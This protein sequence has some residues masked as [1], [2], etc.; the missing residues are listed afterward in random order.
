MPLLPQPLLLPRLLPPG[1]RRQQRRRLPGLPQRQVHALRGRRVEPAAVLALPCRLLWP[2]AVPGRLPRPVSRH[3]PRP[4]VRAGRHRQALQRHRRFLRLLSPFSRSPS[5]GPQR[6]CT[7]NLVGVAG[8]REACGGSVPGQGGEQL[9]PG[10]RL[11]LRRQ[12]LFDP[13]LAHQRLLVLISAHQRRWLRLFRRRLHQ[14]GCGC[15]AAAGGV[16]VPR[17]S[18]LRLGGRLGCDADVIAQGRQ[19]GGAQ[20]A[21]DRQLEERQHAVRLRHS[22]HWRRQRRQYP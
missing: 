2:R 15:P 14:D 4:A 16:A 11:H 1:L 18:V 17:E 3:L 20:D 19:G 8:R 7:G 22:C 10:S 5:A 13:A 12:G 9:E 21:G 6:Q